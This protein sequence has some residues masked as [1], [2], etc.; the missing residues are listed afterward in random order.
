[1][2]RRMKHS[3]VEVVAQLEIE[4]FSH[5]WS[6]ASLIKEVEN[7][8]SLFLVYETEQKIIGYIGMYLVIDEADITNIAITKS[9]RGKGYGRKLLMEAMNHVFMANYQAITLE[10]RESN[11]TAI[12]LYEETGFEIEGVRKNFYDNPTENALIMWKRK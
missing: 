10:V 3:D 7:A 12:H 8:N 4:C 1:M 9:Y 2:I 11:Q 6:E 5:P